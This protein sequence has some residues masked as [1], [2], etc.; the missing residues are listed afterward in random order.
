MKRKMVISF[1]DERS[2]WTITPGALAQIAAALPGDWELT[3]VHAPVSSKGDGGGISPEAVQAIR[4]AEVYAGMGFPRALIQ[5]ADSL[6]W[7]HTGAAGVGALL[8]PEM[9]ASDI[10]LTNSAGIHAHPVA[11]TVIGAAL[12]FARGFDFVTSGKQRHAWDQS[13]FATDHSPVAELG[14]STMGIFGYGGIG[15]EVARRAHVLGM[16][17]IAA[18]RSGAHPDPHAEVVAADDH[19]TRRLLAESDFL[20]MALPSTAETRGLIGAPEI[21]LLKTSAVVINLARG[22]IVVEKDL[23]EA[24]GAGRIRGAALD[25]FEHEPLAADS[26]LWTLPNTLIL[27]HVSATS[28][29]YWEREADLMVTNM[30][31]YLAGEPLLNVVDKAAGY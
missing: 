18:R 20:V 24:L 15:R 9:I 17:V 21:A 27:P 4:G 10:L 5:A 22:N 16:R 12:Y 31:R 30:R 8:Y 26:P 1:T 13:Q 29:R 19:G 28:P 14:G 25:V 23:I 3:R 7:V 11:E 6:R 2:R